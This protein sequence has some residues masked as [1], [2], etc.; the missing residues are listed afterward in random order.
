[1]HETM[2][3]LHKTPDARIRLIG[4]GAY[5]APTGVDFPPHQHHTWELVYY[6]NGYIQ[7][8]VGHEQ[9]S[10]QPGM[11]LLTPPHTV[12]AEIA[13]TAYSNYY[14]AVDAPAD[15]PWGRRCYDDQ[16]RNLESIC[17][18][19]VREWGGRSPDRET[20]LELLLC[21]LDILLRRARSQQQI[22]DGESVV[23]AAERLLEERFAS[24]ITIEQAAREIGVSPSNLRALFARLRG[25]SPLAHL[26][27]VRLRRATEFL[28]NSSLTLERIAALCGYDS[29]S[30][31][32][33]HVKRATGKSPGALRIR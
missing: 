18:A 12:H 33:R 26:H 14:I 28:R 17:R 24:E 15:H 8:P 16:D 1:M 20:M 4:A 27:A 23:R 5:Q 30:H 31:L 11:L 21:Q 10:S 7:C 29:A 6:R 2:Q 3:L 19:M 22:S 9:Y 13:V 25:N 32:S